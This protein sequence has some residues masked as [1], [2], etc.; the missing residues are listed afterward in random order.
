MNKKNL[1]LTSTVGMS[2]QDWLAFRQPM[3]HVRKF[4]IEWLRKEI[5]DDFVEQEDFFIRGKD[6]YTMLK[7]C[8]GTQAWKDFIFPT[9]GAS[10]IAALLGLNP[11]KSIIELY[12]EKIGAKPVF[13]FDN[14]A[15]F[16]GRELEEQIADKWQYYDGSTE[17]MIAN[18]AEKKIIRKCRRVNAYMQN[19]NFP[20]LFVSLDR[21]INKQKTGQE[22]LNEGP[23]ECKTISGYVAKM[24]E[25]GI[26]PMYVAQ[27]QGQIAVGEMEYGEMAVL[28]DGRWFELYPFDKHPKIT[29]K[30]IQETGNFFNMVKKGIQHFLL[31]QFCPFESGQ[32]DHWAACEQ[33]SPDPD[34]SDAYKNYLSETYKESIAGKEV[35]GG[36]DELELAS[37]YKYYAA[38][39]K[40]FEFLQTECANKLKN[41]MKD[42]A[43]LT[44][45]NEGSCTWRKGA[46]GTRIFRVNVKITKNYL[47]EAFR[48]RTVPEKPKAVTKPKEKKKAEKKPAA[49]KKAVVVFREMR[50]TLKKAAKKGKSGKK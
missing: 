8:F 10:E 13:D 37:N 47:P 49:K 28:K 2:R 48:D 41:F 19:K 36:V 35:R 12:F 39:Q 15:M 50:P 3:T 16:W 44:F 27:L 46:K 31:H 7:K 23:L 32:Q 25:G 30:I 43:K 18:F 14:D 9:I 6:A 21:V 1:I 24:W 34:G 5:D 17:G 11:Y 33:L 42:A 4:V 45:G 29:A 22:V 40:D 26:P 20:W 38:R